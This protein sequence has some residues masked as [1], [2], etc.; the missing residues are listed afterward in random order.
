MAPE[1]HAQD[2][3]SARIPHGQRHAHEQRAPS[4]IEP[5]PAHCPLVGER[6]QAHDRRIHSAVNIASTWPRPI[7]HGWT[8]Q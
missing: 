7:T 2:T 3:R 5:E 6:T 8:G 1:P 4:D